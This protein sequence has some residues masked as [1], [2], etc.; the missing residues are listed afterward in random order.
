MSTA[1][2]S[3]GRPLTVAAAGGWFRPV[4][5]ASFPPGRHAP[6]MRPRASPGAA[7]DD[8]AMSAAPAPMIVISGPSGVGKST[9]SR[10]VAAAFERSVHVQADALMAFVVN[11]WVDPW[12]PEAEHQHEVV[13]GALAV[14]A[15]QFAGGGY[16]TVV[17][18]HLF[19]R[20]VQGLAVACASR[21][22]PVHYVVL[23]ADLATCWAR[24]SDRGEG[25]WA[26]EPV[27]FA[28]SH[29]RFARI[30]AHE[31]HVVG[32]TGR[33]EDVAARVLTAFRA[34]IAVTG[35]HSSQN[36]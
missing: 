16:T 5:R 28:E 34:G 26:L 32:A 15:M 29:A 8:A 9:V 35:E 10:L 30:G 4:T 11:G 13:G 33:P 1:T 19:P 27:T 14:A 20:G 23:R 2:D 24:A 31:A 12:L 18:G 6:G 17:D 25:H 22:V 21:S 36:G 3:A 7:G